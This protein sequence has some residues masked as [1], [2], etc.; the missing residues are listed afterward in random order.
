MWKKFNKYER[1]ILN[2]CDWLLCFTDEDEEHLLVDWFT[3]IHE[4]HLLVRREAELVYTSV[5]CSDVYRSVPWFFSLSWTLRMFWHCRAKQQNLEERQ[6]DVEYELRCLLNKPGVWSL[7]FPERAATHTFYL[8]TPHIIENRNILII[9][10]LILSQ[11]KT[12]LRRTK[13]GSRSSWLSWLPSLNSG[14]KL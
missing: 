11:R 6:A 13:V 1:V 12:G 9:S 14:T 8:R 3:L 7:H 10:F 5:P 4:K 2:P